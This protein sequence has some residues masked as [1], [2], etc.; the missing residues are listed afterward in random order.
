[1]NPIRERIKQLEKAADL[2]DKIQLYNPPKFI[3]VCEIDGGIYLKF[4]NLD[5]FKK[6]ITFVKKIFPDYKYEMRTKLISCG[7][8]IFTWED[9]NY[10]IIIWFECPHDQIPNELLGNCKVKKHNKVVYDIVCSLDN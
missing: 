2:Y 9:K 4:N 7:Y 5:F 8:A 1:M 6:V 3:K 10:P